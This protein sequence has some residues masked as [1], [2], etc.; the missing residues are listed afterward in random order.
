MDMKVGL[1]GAGFIGGSHALAMNA[2]NRV[3]G[4][5]VPFVVPHMLVEAD[6]AKAHQ[7]AT[8]FGFE[9]S[10][11]DWRDAIKTC[12]AIII[13]VPSF[14]HKEIAL[15]AIDAGKH[16]LC[17]KPVGLSD[18][19]AATIAEAA[20][21]AEVSHMVG[22]TYL[23]SPL[24]RYAKQLVDDERLG[25]PLHFKGWHFED[26]LADPNLPFTWRQDASLAGECGALGDMGW[27]VL[28]IARALCGNVIE[29]NGMVETF[30]KKRPL[31]ADPSTYRDVENED[32]ANV[33][34]K[35]ESGAVGSLEVS[36]VAHGR[37]MDIGFEL[38]CEQ[39][40]IA[41]NGEQSNQIEVFSAGED[42]AGSG[43]R[44][45]HINAQHPDYAR[46]I[47]APGHGLGFNDLKTIEMRDFLL[48][49]ATRQQ[50]GADLNEAVR[51][52]R[53]CN[54]ILQSSRAGGRSVPLPQS[55]MNNV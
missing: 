4:D 33:T 27:H 42:S 18:R 44:T 41:F 26:Y 2:V 23:R 37:K 54:A 50:A 49:I 46:F 29:L 8:Q 51:L 9:T 22:F 20:R 48:S 55:A 11:N 47:P 5:T 38:V 19:E 30:H 1:I 10:S 36:R 14:L 28:A 40:T 35:F 43:F 21:F 13:A 15:A 52:S 3:F 7:L 24:I 45:I 6:A 39:G 53:I 34:L 25:K 31:P 16:I 12:D 32:W 17:E